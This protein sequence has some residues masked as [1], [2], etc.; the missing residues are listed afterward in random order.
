MPEPMEKTSLDPKNLPGNS[1]SEKEK[2]GPGK[3]IQGQAIT[4]KKS[5]GRRMADLLIGENV[6]DVKTYILED[7]LVPTIK[8]TISDIIGGGVDMLLFPGQSR[9]RRFGSRSNIGYTSYTPYNSLNNRN[10]QP[11]PYQNRTVPRYGVDEIILGTRGEADDVLAAMSDYMRDY[12]MVAVADLY[13][14]VGHP[15]VFTDNNWGWTDLRSSSVRK[16][17]EGYLLVL[18]RP[19]GLK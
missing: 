3:V 9:S 2:K 6:G 17:P 10:L 12:G 19:M 16:I 11:T 15:I 18:P 5:F 8:A 7:V 13:E 14:M 4:R 1:F